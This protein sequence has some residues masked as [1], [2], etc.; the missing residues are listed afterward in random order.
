ML[1]EWLQGKDEVGKQGG[2]TWRALVDGLR[3][4]L[5]KQTQIAETIERELPIFW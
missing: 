5:L 1:K 4:P 2:H 3:H